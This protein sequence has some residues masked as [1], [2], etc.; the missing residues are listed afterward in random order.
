MLQVD[1]REWCGSL[2]HAANR[3]E[4]R[5]LSAFQGRYKPGEGLVLVA[6]KAKHGRAFDTHAPDI[7]ANATQPHNI[8][9][10]PVKTVTG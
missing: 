8:R 7:A 2:V 5:S 3:F 1:N 6:A 10:L 9:A 4:G